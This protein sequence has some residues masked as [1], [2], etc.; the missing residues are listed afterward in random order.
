MSDLFR[1]VTYAGISRLSVNTQSDNQAS[2]NLYQRMGF[3]RTG[4]EYPVYMYDVTVYA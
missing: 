3:L 1:Y 2:L 4:E